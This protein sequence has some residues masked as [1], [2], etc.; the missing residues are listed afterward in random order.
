MR[1]FRAV[2]SFR[3]FAAFGIVTLH[4]AFFLG[5]SHGS[6][7]WLLLRDCSLPFFTMAAFFLLTAALKSDPSRSWSAFAAKRFVR[8]EVPLLVWTAVFWAMFHVL[9]PLLRGRPAEWPTVTAFAEGY[10]HLW[11]L[12]FVFV[13]GLIGFPLLKAAA[14]AGL[15]GGP[16]AAVLTALA[17]A[18]VLDPVREG[19]ERLVRDIQS[20]A[21]GNLGILTGSARMLPYVLLGVAAACVREPLTA[22]SSR[23][24]YGAAAFALFAGGGALHIAAD[25]GAESR[26][27][28]AAATFLLCL[29]SWPEWLHRITH[30]AANRSYAIYILHLPFAVLVVGGMRKLGL[31]HGH[32]AAIL[33]AAAAVFALT[34][35][36]AERIAA[37]APWAWL[38]PANFESAPPAPARMIGDPRPASPP[39]A[40]RRLPPPRPLPLTAFASPLWG[41]G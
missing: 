14:R 23:T 9:W 15:L 2:D 37:I 38:L 7:P 24:G 33:G 17:A 22:L 5:E 28:Y 8:L 34:L 6:Q 25:E 3:A 19:A 29:A 20:A 30:A 27:I 26:M 40:A 41:E 39:T 4:T 13:A 18:M 31:A 10:W 16:T 12:Q 32:P 1:R 21:G 35:A 36:A 11:F